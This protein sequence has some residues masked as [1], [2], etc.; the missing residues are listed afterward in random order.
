[1]TGQ[2][3]G[4][5]FVRFE[6]REEAECAR[7]AM[8][9][10]TPNGSSKPI[11][12]KVHFYLALYFLFLQ[13][14][15]FPL[16]VFLSFFLFTFFLLFL[17]KILLSNANLFFQHADENKRN[18]QQQRGGGMIRAGGQGGQYPRYDPYSNPYAQAAYD[19]SA[20]Y[21]YPAGSMAA[22]SYGTPAANM[23]GAGAGYGANPY[24]QVIASFLCFKQI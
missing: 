6:T 2:S 1:M 15:L 19:Y 13:H 18:Q 8:N 12:V 24:G 16:P 4:V 7:V 9:A 21:G 23:Q 10:T 11:Y 20:Y 3:R 22:G 14:I 5:G 17:S